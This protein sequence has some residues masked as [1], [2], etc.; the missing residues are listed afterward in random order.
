MPNKTSHSVNYIGLGIREFRRSKDLTLKDLAEII[1]TSAGYISEIERGQKI[2]GSK[3]ISS[4]KRNYEGLDLNKLFNIQGKEDPVL[5]DL[6]LDNDQGNSAKNVTSSK[7]EALIKLVEKI[8]QGPW[9][10][11]KKVKLMDS[12]FSI[13]GTDLDKE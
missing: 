12:L 2:P 7:E 10:D 13:V 6:T 9:S 5:K 1:D 4:L 11:K 3:L 8:K